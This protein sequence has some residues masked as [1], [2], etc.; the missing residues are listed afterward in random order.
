[1]EKPAVPANTQPAVFYPSPPQQG[2]TVLGS[3]QSP[4]PPNHP[5]YRGHVIYSK[6]TPCGIAWCFPLGLI[7]LFND[8]RKY[9]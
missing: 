5:C 4:L 3:P 2:N 9:C 8:R 7:C 1:M 6:F